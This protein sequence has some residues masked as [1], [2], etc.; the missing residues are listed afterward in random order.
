MSKQITLIAEIEE[1][2][3]SKVRINYESLA[4]MRTLWIPRTSIHQMMGIEDNNMLMILTNTE[5]S[6]GQFE[7]EKEF[8][9]S[10]SP[11]I[12]TDY[13][14][15]VD[16]LETG[17][18]AKAWSQLPKGEGE[19]ET[20]EEVETSATVKTYIGADG[21]EI[22]DVWGTTLAGGRNEKVCDWNFTP[23]ILPLMSQDEDDTVHNVNKI[24]GETALFGGFNPNY[25]S[26]KRPLGAFLGAYSDRY[27]AGSYSERAGP[28][29]Q[30]AAE[31]GWLA[32]AI[33]YDEGKKFRADFDLTDSM[34]T[35]SQWKQTMLA[36]KDAQGII[37]DLS[38]QYRIG[39]TFYDSLD[40]RG[41]VTLQGQS[42]RILCTNG[43]V[44]GQKQNIS[45]LR[46]MK[47]P[48]KDRDWDAYSHQVGNM[49]VEAQ[50]HLLN[51]ETLKGISLDQKMF[52][53]LMFL[54]TKHGLFQ[55]PK[56]TKS[57]T[58]LMGGYLY[59]AAREGFYNG[60]REHW[61]N[62]S[63]AE[64]GTAYHAL[65]AFTGALTH[66]PEI[67]PM[68]GTGQRRSLKGQALSLT[69]YRALQ[70]GTTLLFQNFFG[71][72]ERQAAIENRSGLS[73][74][75]MR[76]WS[77]SIDLDIPLLVEVAAA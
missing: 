37:G 75:Q 28:M 67:Q 63:S 55:V 61:V 42:I 77:R 72:I 47:G 25:K 6:A 18:F 36:N 5:T 53:Q 51:M 39:M 57:G 71:R 11:L 69:R 24:T 4:G 64:I 58:E 33:A 7:V 1:T 10:D 19:I 35:I 21:Q 66:R 29:L 22:V 52:E 31:S 17:N 16:S 15:A 62:V 30:R 40:G 44:T 70:E 14:A 60:A 68:Q 12:P 27:Y 59:E 48:M 32:S 26:E 76:E 50:E 41:S 45:S 56:A 74:S 13:I 9:E 38:K 73:I 8:S 23:N 3:T 49:M 43:M 20:V 46:H 2:S 54:A 34:Q 65:Q